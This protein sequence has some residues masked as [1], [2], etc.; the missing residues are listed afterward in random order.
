MDFKRLITKPESQED[1]CDIKKEQKELKEKLR[2][3]G[4][5]E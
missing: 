2:V 3:L 5:F 1:R 4:Y